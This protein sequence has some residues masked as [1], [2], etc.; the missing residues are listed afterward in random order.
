MP[1]ISTQKR[2]KISEHILANLFGNSPEALFTNK[3]AQEIA[4]DEEFTKTL[5]QELEKKKLIIQINKNSQGVLYKKRQR[6][7]LSNTTFEVYNK[8]Q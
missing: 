2:E 6:W 5:L 3:I 8:H 4:R 7:R 1:K